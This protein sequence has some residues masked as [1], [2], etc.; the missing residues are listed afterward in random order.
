MASTVAPSLFDPLV[1]R[2]SSDGAP[3]LSRSEMLR[4]LGYSGQ[5]L[6]QDLQQRIEDAAAAVVA[7]ARICGTRRVF[8]V[9]A[10][11]LDEQ[12]E[13]CIALEGTCVRLRGRDIFRH[14]KDARYA[15][16]ICCTLGMQ[17]ERRLRAMGA[18]DALDAALYDAACSAYAED[19][20][21]IL[22]ADTREAG[23]AN[24]L[25]A[26]WRFSCGYGDCPLDAQP[27]ILAALNAQR[28]CGITATPTNLLLPS[29]SIT[30]VIGLFE[31]PV[32]DAQTRPTCSICRLRPS[33]AF[34]ARGTTCYQKAGA[35]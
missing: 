11:A 23:L 20:V 19:A 24:G 4:Y 1:W 8:P 5:E 26:N 17:T 27:A 30:C 13:P 18:G 14:L 16:L 32:H 3:A 22:D 9:D 31:G 15:A 34:R 2:P 7:D 6:D 10:S 12:G 35:H 33:C 25:N 29:K 21:E 28:L